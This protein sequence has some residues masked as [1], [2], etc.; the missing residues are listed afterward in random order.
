VK[1]ISYPD[2]SLA[3][4]SCGQAC[5]IPPPRVQSRKYAALLI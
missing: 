1:A 4:R 5:S 3:Q 2:H